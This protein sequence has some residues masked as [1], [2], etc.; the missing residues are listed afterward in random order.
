M[1]L[2]PLRE[3]VEAKAGS[4]KMASKAVPTVSLIVPPLRVRALVARY[5]KSAEVSPACTT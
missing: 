3:L 1:A 4:I 2:L 5:C